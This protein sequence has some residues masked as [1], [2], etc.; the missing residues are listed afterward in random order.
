M[1][2]PS[3]YNEELQQKFDNLVEKLYTPEMTYKEAEENFWDYGIVEQL[4]AYL[5]VSME[6]LYDWTDVEGDRFKPEFSETLKKWYMVTKALLHK[7]G[8]LMAVKAP[9]VHIFMRKNKLGEL[10]I[11]KH[12]LEARLSTRSEKNL[13]IKVTKELEEA[14]MLGVE[15]E[16]ID[17][18]RK[19]LEVL[20]REQKMITAKGA[21]QTNEN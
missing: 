15:K 6:T 16:D 13:Y 21:G 9:A 8:K 18:V 14:E 5:D 3:K 19:L 20:Q 12:I 4:A 17:K 11:S 2:R 7:S 1:A 10:E